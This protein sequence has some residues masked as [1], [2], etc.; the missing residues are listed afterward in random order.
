MRFVSISGDVNKPGVY[1][2][3]FGQTVKELVFDTAGGLRDGQRSL[4]DGDV[5]GAR[6]GFQ[7]GQGGLRLGQ[8]G[9]G[10]GFGANGLVQRRLRLCERCHLLPGVQAREHLPRCHVVALRDQHVGN[11]ARHAQAQVNAPDR[12]DASLGDDALAQRLSFDGG[13]GW[14]GLDRHGLSAVAAAKQQ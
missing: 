1:E 13:R 11:G 2:V 3:P 14:R 10:D 7:Q 9:L 8:C 4:G 5:L 6:A 12:C